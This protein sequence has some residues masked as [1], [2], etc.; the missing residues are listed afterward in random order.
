MSIG[1]KEL[2]LI[3]ILCVIAYAFVF[4]KFI[5]QSVIPSIR[6][7]NGDVAAALG[8][9]ELLEEDF[10]N[11]DTYKTQLTTQKTSNER[12]DEYLMNSA[13]MVDSLEYVDKLTRLIGDNIREM[14]IAKPEQ[15]YV[16]NGKNPAA[17]DTELKEDAKKNKTYYEIKM[18]FRAY[19][20]YSSAMELVKYI[21]G[22]TRR[23]K[24]T[25]FFVK[26]LADSDLKML[27]DAKTKQEQGKTG[28]TA[29][30]LKSAVQKDNSVNTVA[31]NTAT[32][33]TVMQNA[34]T[35]ITTPENKLFDTNMT[36]SIYSTNLRASDRMYEY[37][38]HKLNRFIYTNGIL[39][40]SSGSVASLN[41]SDPVSSLDEEF[42]SSDIIIKE[43]SYLAA[44]ENLQ[45]FGVDRE[46]NIIR[47]KT[48]GTTEIRISLIGNSYFVDTVEN[49]KKSLAMTGS[50]PDKSVITLAV[51]VAM[52]SIKENDNIRLDIKINNNSG[53]DLN[54]TLDDL[55]KRVNI[56]DRNGNKIYSDSTA[57]KVRII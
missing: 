8:K 51:A 5:W 56:S 22:G 48:A 9:L 7:V 50:L 39:L 6:T 55:Q 23:V 45:I 46:K 28:T 31:Q 57:E 42:G 36:I 26:A 53:R 38:R 47:L 35:Q 1:K 32:Q 13:N 44:G 37:S 10:G 14:N 27:T 11:L 30:A 24:I 34:D 4:Y 20:T 49:G 29:D 19:M 3:A 16:L 25:K 33:N 21:E 2:R 12:I 52:P 15:K 40:T 18:D 41:A 43:R 17:D 54:I